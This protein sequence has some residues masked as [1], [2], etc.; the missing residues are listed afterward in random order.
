MILTEEEAIKR[1]ESLIRKFAIKY[2]HGWSVEIEDLVQ[3][4]RIAVA[5]AVRDYDPSKGAAFI[6]FAYTRIRASMQHCLR[7]RGRIIRIPGWLQDRPNRNMDELPHTVSMDAPINGNDG[8]AFDKFVVD[9]NDNY[10]AIEEND[11]IKDMARTIKPEDLQFLK[12]I[13]GDG[14]TSAEAAELMGMDIKAPRMKSYNTLMRVRKDV[15]KRPEYRS[16][17][18]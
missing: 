8:D 7:D 16:I 9:E 17:C 3:E 1:Y 2:A 5:L 14:Y 13:Y 10:E 12:L 11:V 15:K 18:V 6:T 4:G